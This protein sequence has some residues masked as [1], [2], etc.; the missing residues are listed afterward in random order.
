MRIRNENPSRKEET[1]KASK[2][3]KDKKH[4]SYHHQSDEEEANSL[5]KLKKRFGKYK[6]KLPFKCFNYAKIGNYSKKGIY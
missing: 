5:R 4:Q 3:R 1:F 2:G 6:D